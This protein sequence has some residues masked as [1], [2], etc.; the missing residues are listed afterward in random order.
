MKK[1]LLSLMVTIMSVTMTSCDEDV[2][3]IDPQDLPGPALSFIYTFYPGDPIWNVSVGGDW[4]GGYYQVE[5]SSGATVY[6]DNYGN[7][8]AVYAPW[9]YGIPYGIVPMNIE[10]D[11]AAYYPWAT[12]NSACITN[13][14]YLI[15][16][17]DG[18]QL[19][20]DSW[21]RPY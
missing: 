8:Y 10:N 5:M 4:D 15:T 20:Y 2:Y 18:T 21:G 7:W 6:F 11:V 17:T 12:I 16:L 9:G 13:Y 14:G 3:Y 1:L 19:S